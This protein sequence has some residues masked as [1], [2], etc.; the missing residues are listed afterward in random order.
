[1]AR[2]ILVHG[3]C[4]GAW[5]WRDVI[6]ALQAEG[7]EVT[8]LDMPGRGGGVAG[9]TLADQTD[10]ILSAYE[11]RAVLVGHSAGGFS[12]SAAAEAAPERVSRL[13]FVT[14]LLPVDGEVLGRKMQ[15]LKGTRAPVPLVVAPDRL[16]Y[17][18]DL[19][20]AGEALYNGVSPEGIDWAL[21][22]VCNEPSDPHRE[23]IRVGAAF[24]SVPK[25]YV[26][27]TEDRMIPAV[28][29]EAMAAGLSDVVR[30]ATGH[31]PF[32]ST[33]AELAGHLSRMAA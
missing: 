18:F 2:I 33:P 20:S 7:H 28:D 11:G 16:S 1:M 26:I 23:P 13:I 22:Q 31:S 10:T 17:S 5:C 15:G 24:A 25:S 4:H 29:Q 8:A 9:L 3:A 30:I 27:C 12:I 21:T 14:A 6:P 19:S 32:L